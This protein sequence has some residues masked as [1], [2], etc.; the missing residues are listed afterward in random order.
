MR[1]FQVQIVART[2]GLGRGARDYARSKI[3]HLARYSPRPVLFARVELQRLP[4]PAVRQPAL[5][6]ATLLL[7]GHRLRAH[8]HAAAG[9]LQEAVDQLQDRLRHQLEHLSSRLRTPATHP[10][11]VRHPRE[12]Q[13]GTSGWTPEQFPLDRDA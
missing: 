5:A 12:Q 4:D 10:Q 9:D 1:D 8:A 7:R 3:T 11:R 13:G 2:D 6:E